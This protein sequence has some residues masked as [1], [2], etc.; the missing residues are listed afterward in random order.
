[1]N[2]KDALLIIEKMISSV[3]DEVK[4]N[5]FYFM[6]WGWLVFAAALI[7][8]A[9]LKGV[10]ESLIEY[11]AI[12]WAILMPIGGVVSIIGSMKKQ[13]EKT[14]VKTYIDDIMSYVTKAFAIS[15]FIICFIMPS[16]DNWPSFYPVLL[17][18]YA[19]WLFISGGALKFKPL[20]WGGYA[21]WLL[22]IIAFFVKYDIQLLLLA[23]A[24]LVGYIIPGYLLNRR[25]EKNV[26]GA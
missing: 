8:Y 25:F 5:G 7:D 6:L 24:V 12:T 26:Q 3:K 22:A 1:M 18:V 23:T 15:L 13:K 16:T 17:I 9:L 11:H 19:L 21:N 2:E 4:S 14:K 20:V 10:I